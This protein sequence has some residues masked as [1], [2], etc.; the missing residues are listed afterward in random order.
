MI[1]VAAVVTLSSG[2]PAQAKKAAVP[3]K[4]ERPAGW[5]FRTDTPR[6]RPDVISF[7]ATRTGMHVSAGMSH[8]IYW[9][10]ANQASGYFS[11]SG[12][13]TQTKAPSMGHPEAYG[14]FWGGADL[15][16]ERVSYLYFVIRGD[17]KYLVVHRAD[18]MVTHIITDWTASPA[19]NAQDASG[20]QVNALEVRVDADSVR[21]FANG[22]PVATYDAK[23]MASPPGLY[24]FR[25]GHALDIEVSG[26]ARK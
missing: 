19:I 25:V 18:A 12:T 17:G 7:T 1:V 6:E 22:K 9:N 16:G 8:A 13:F 15:T 26:F 4:A 3:A 5:Q 23:V 14:I 24:G 11:V 10:D 21:M 20:K 2:A